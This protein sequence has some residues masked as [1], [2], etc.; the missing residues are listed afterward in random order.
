MLATRI[1]T[2]YYYAFTLCEA[3]RQS[4]STV[5]PGAIFRVSKQESDPVPD[6]NQTIFA[7]VLAAGRSSRFGSNKLIAELEGV[8][9]VRRAFDLATSV[10]DDRVL[11]VVGH[12]A[13]SILDSMSANTGFILVNDNYEN[14]LGSSI[15]VAARACR[16]HADALLLLLAD[17]ALVTADHLRRLLDRWSGSDTEIVA[18]AFADSQG[19]PVLMPRKTI[20]ELCTLSGDTGARALFEDKRFQLQT[21]RFD[22][23]AADIDT[24]ADLDALT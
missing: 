11:T 4:C 3:K 14:G 18:T 8:A 20:G 19:P 13:T 1:H 23:A 22:P 9:L 21:V 7:V 17:Q 6:R 2:S 10:C 12:D 24:P 16:P 15:A 5:H